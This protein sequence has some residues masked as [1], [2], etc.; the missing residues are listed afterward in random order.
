MESVG[1]RN[2]TT[3]VEPIKLEVDIDNQPLSRLCDIAIQAWSSIAQA[4]GV[5]SDDTESVDQLCEAAVLL[6]SSLA[7]QRATTVSDLA[8]KARLWRCIAPDDTFDERGQTPDEY[9]LVSIM[10][11]IENLEEK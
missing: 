3:S 1:Y 7:S 11:D 9:F 5:F 10:N 8:A 4:N 6:T 2:E